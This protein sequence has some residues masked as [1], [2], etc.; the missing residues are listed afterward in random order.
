VHGVGVGA[1]S[2]ASGTDAYGVYAEVDAYVETGAYV[3]T[4]AYAGAGMDIGDGEYVGGEY[5]NG[6]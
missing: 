2:G 4:G 3:G 1:Y 6:G 5:A